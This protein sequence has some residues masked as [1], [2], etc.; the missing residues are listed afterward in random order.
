VGKTCSNA[1]KFTRKL[2]RRAQRR[3]LWTPL[4]IASLAGN[5]LPVATQEVLAATGGVAVTSNVYI[6][7]TPSRAASA[8]IDVNVDSRAPVGSVSTASPSSDIDV[9]I[10]ARTFLARPH[11]CA[12]VATLTL[13]CAFILRSPRTGALPAISGARRATFSAPV[14]AASG[15]PF[16]FA[17]LHLQHEPVGADSLGAR[18]DRCC[19]V[20]TYA[21]SQRRRSS[22]QR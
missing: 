11:P 4:H 21:K 14:L 20:N 15:G 10:G 8:L 2:R 3:P 5:A 6:G 13:C 12:T 17:L 18:G 19:L 1:E 7:A 9:D 16:V 22:A